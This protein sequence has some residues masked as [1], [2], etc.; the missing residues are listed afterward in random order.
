MDQ[1]TAAKEV[2]SIFEKNGHEAYIVGGYVRDYLLNRVST[3]IDLATSA[4]PLETIKLFKRTA[5]TGLKHGTVTILWKG[6]AFESTTF[7]KEGAYLDHRRPEEVMFVRGF[8]EDVKRRDFTMNALGMAK[9]G[10]IIDYVGGRDDIE[11]K[12]IRTVGEASARFHEDAL[13]ML[14]AF[15]FLSELEFDFHDDT[16]EAIKKEGSLIQDI[17]L[18]R[19]VQEFR[20]LILGKA[21][22]KAFELMEATGFL[23]HLPFYERGIQE[24]LKRRYVPTSEA[25]FYTVLVYYGEEGELNALPLSKPLKL[26]IA[27]MLSLLHTYEKKREEAM[28]YH[29]LALF[30]Y[31]EEAMLEANA[32]TTAL[33]DGSDRTL[34]IRQRY[35]AL[36]IKEK[37]ELAI[38]GE[39]L[40]AWFDRKRGPW[41]G[42]LIEQAI[43]AVVF[44]QIK[45]EKNE[46]RQYLLSFD[47]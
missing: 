24:L 14:R 12:I 30:H 23:K 35:K 46:I 22:L 9:D 3:D 15:R 43:E 38:D 47:T 4:T 31:G 44:G 18:E 7:R 42:Q 36:P 11:R 6:H 33:F 1:L 39:D 19:V 5:K 26:S 45:N 10:E 37:A 27:S 25:A 13:R 8:E 29:P 2:L 34:E 40:M 20:S 21:C 16:H 28:F 32:L 41:I 17:S